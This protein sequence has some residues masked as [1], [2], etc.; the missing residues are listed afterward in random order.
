MVAAV[1]GVL[2]VSLLL[3][4]LGVFLALT[5]AAAVLLLLAFSLVVLGLGLATLGRVLVSSVCGNL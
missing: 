2:A 1:A 5:R 4:V 3:A